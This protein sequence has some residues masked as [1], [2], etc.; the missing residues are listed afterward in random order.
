[1]SRTLGQV[2]VER[3]AH[4][5][6]AVARHEGR[7]IFVRH[8]APGELVDVRVEEDA[9]DAR[10]WR[11]E[12]V[13]V[14]EPSPDRVAHVWP[15][16]GPGGVG[17]AELGHLRLAAQRAWKR[18]VL[19]ETLTRVGHL[20]APDLEVR[21]APGDED[22]GGLGTRTRITMV[23]DA[24]GR[25]AMHR[26]R[27]HELVPIGEMP[28][29]VPAL[30]DLAVWDSRVRAGT[31]LD[32]VAP[33]EPSAGAFVL[34]D[35]ERK[36]GKGRWVTEQVT[37]TGPDG[38]PRTYRYRVAA[39]G[40]WQTHR[41]APGV[42]AETVL[43]AADLQEGER[44][45]ELYSGAGL[46]TLPL[47][48]AVGPRGRIDAVEGDASGSR[49]ARRNAREHPWIRLHA[50][51]VR[52]VVGELST[53]AQERPDVVVLDPPRAGARREVMAAIT[54]ATP[55]RIVYVACD[56]A[57]LA[58]DAAIAVEHGYTLTSVQGLDLFPHTH[59]VEAV[60]VLD[61]EG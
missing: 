38:L 27:S 55:R 47:A 42:I 20:E 8:T 2:R 25:P 10:F 61:R 22:R 3:P 31:R 56:P 18:E 49:A 11:G 57:S 6:H 35:G 51:D 33:S 53:H 9:P 21:A 44:V 52:T 32:L 7:V 45:W 24:E 30:A 36:G 60:A 41:E 29:A 58:R 48:D 15:A 5:G 16:A 14:H 1:M 50:G 40:F 13:V 28:L 26:A 46:L 43:Q 34:A 37:V 19:I 23:A 4:G 12:A 54:A 59:H 39:D 17:G